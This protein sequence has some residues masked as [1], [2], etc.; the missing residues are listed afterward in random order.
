VTW[1]KVVGVVEAAAVAVVARAVAAVKGQAGWMAP[2]LLGRV[3]PASVP[4]AGTGSRTW[5]DSPAIRRSAR[6]VARR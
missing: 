5:L 1:V 2:W 4:L 6:S 3:A